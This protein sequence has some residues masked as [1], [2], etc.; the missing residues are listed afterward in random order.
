MTDR[1]TKY[2]FGVEYSEAATAAWLEERRELLRRAFDDG[3]VSWLR[4][5]KGAA[6]N[7][8]QN[9]MM[10]MADNL[11]AAGWRPPADTPATE[12]ESDA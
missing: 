8:V 10:L 3:K 9:R 11:I 4:Y 12:G 1:E 5:A 2:L 6:V 7:V